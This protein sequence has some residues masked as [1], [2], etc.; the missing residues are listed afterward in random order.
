MSTLLLQ[1]TAT[2]PYGLMYSGGPSPPG[3]DSRDVSPAAMNNSSSRTTQ[4]STL[5]DALAPIPSLSTLP[6]SARPII[7]LPRSYRPSPIY[8]APGRQMSPGSEQHLP[9]SS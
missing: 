7:P 8:T 4:Y 5:N 9:S 2:S 3:S 1:S 6:P